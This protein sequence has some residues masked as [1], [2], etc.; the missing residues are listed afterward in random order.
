M[1]TNKMI[2]TVDVNVGLYSL[3]VHVT[4]SCGVNSTIDALYC[5]V[6]NIDL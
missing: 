3:N 4:Q 5:N 1:K 6:Q 2:G